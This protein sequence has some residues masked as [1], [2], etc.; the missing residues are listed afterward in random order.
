VIYPSAIVEVQEADVFSP[1]QEIPVALVT[2]Q[3]IFLGNL[4]TGGR[5]LQDILNDALTDYL[6]LR[7]VQISTTME[8]DSVVQELTHAT[9]VKES[10]LLGLLRQDAHEAPIKRQNYRVRRDFC[11]A[12]I[13]I[14]T[15][16]IHGAIHLPRASSQAS[17]IL[18]RDLKNFFA[19]T[20][21]T[22]M[23][24]TGAEKVMTTSV[25]MVNKK[26][27]SLFHV[28]PVAQ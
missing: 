7:N 11:E 27:L 23:Y 25:V 28:G 3:F 6:S 9:I 20:D 26:M 15:L 14:K 21:A 5:R 17:A 24:G 1:Q 19:V 4:A 10:L 18:S 12:S 8:G 16:C 2:E 13:V 22:I